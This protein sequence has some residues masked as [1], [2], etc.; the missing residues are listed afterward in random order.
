VEHGIRVKRQS[1]SYSGN[2]DR[3]LR[4]Q[5]HQVLPSHWLSPFVYVRRNRTGGSFFYADM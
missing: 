5:R 2:W 1:K 3:P 4:H